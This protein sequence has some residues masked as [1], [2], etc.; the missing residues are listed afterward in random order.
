MILQ[1]SPPI[2]LTTPKGPG[3]AWILIDYSQEHNLLWVVA[4]DATGEIWAWPNKDVRAQQNL[5]IERNLNKHK[6]EVLSFNPH[7]D[8]K[9]VVYTNGESIIKRIVG[10]GHFI[11]YYETT[12]EIIW[13]TQYLGDSHLR[14]CLNDFSS[15]KTSR[16]C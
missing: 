7:F 14:D 4:D 12:G 11:Y 16:R 2:P 13:D 3:Q 9:I 10:N 6:Q 15:Y 5:S 1:L 8:T